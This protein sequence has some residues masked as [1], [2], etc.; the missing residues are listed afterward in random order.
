MFACWRSTEVHYYN[1]PG[2]DSHI[3]FSS[4]YCDDIHEDPHLPDDFDFPYPKKIPKPFYDNGQIEGIDGYDFKIEVECPYSYSEKRR[5]ELESIVNKNPDVFD[6]G[7]TDFKLFGFPRSQQEAKRYHV[8]NRFV[9]QIEMTPFVSFNLEERDFTIQIYSDL[10]SSD[11]Y[12]VF[13]KVDGSC[14]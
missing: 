12:S 3:H 13:S 7:S 8:T 4:V 5:D 9:P 1:N 6:S 14:T 10:Q 2:C 11:G